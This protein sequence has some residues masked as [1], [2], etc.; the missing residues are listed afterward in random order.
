MGNFA[1]VDEDSAH[2]VSILAPYAFHVHAK[3]WLVH[4]FEEDFPSGYK[5][6]GCRRLVGCSVG[7]GNMPIKRCLAILKSAGYDGYVSIEYEGPNDCIEG[8]RLGIE[9]L[10]SFGV[11][12]E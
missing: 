2:A 3:D 1:C 6:R 5:T 12:T 8:I 10:K 4:E 7:E 9:N 11:T